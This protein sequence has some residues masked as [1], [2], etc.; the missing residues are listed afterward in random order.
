LLN[1][2][3]YSGKFTYNIALVCMTFFDQYVCWG[4]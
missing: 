2:D 3:Y 1:P 4:V